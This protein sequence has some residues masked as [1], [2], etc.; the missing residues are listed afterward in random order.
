M[1]FDKEKLSNDVIYLCDRYQ[2]VSE[3]LRTSEET[4]GR[5]SKSINDVKS[6]IANL[7][8]ERRASPKKERWMYRDWINDAKDRKYNL[9]SEIQTETANLRR[10][11][12]TRNDVLRKSKNLQSKIRSIQNELTRNTNQIS[13]GVLDWA[14]DG[15]NEI[16]SEIKAGKAF[17]QNQ[18]NKLNSSIFQSSNSFEDDLEPNLYLYVKE[19]RHNWGSFESNDG[20]GLN[21]QLVSPPNQDVYLT[22][23][24]SVTVPIVS[25]EVYDSIDVSNS[26]TEDLGTKYAAS[27]LKAD[28]HKVVLELGGAL[29]PDIL[30]LDES[31][32]LWFSETKGTEKARTLNKSG[33]LSQ[34]EKAGV[35][36]YE[37]SRGWLQTKAP[38][39]QESLDRAI[40]EEQNPGI[41]EAL[42]VLLM[43]FNEAMSSGFSPNSFKNQVIQVGRA[44]NNSELRPVTIMKSPFLDDYIKDVRPDRIIQI[45]I[46]GESP[47]ENNQ[48]SVESAK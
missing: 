38:K 45:D 9:I 25:Y 33:L 26:S 10:L 31:N 32:N 6:E 17:V 47:S 44:K 29:R 27:L 34:V 28:G 2:S 7:I 18:L 12:S 37:N 46:R 8:D 42:S 19:E 11:K 39:V 41:K 35:R 30:S 23:D 4:V 13:G 40:Q 24:N 36:L 16:A 22:A 15:F 43:K 3:E 1:S 20:S 21:L 5:L 48:S 14:Y